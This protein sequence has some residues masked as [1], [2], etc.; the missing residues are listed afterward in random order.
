M[1]FVVVD[2]ENGKVKGFKKSTMLGREYFN[3]DGIPYMKAP[4]GKLRFRDAQLPDNWNETLDAS[5]ARPSYLMFPSMTNEVI[6]QEDA[7]TV[8][9]ATPYLNPSK[10][11]PV[12]VYI[13]GGGFQMS[14]GVDD[15]FGGDFLLQ[16]DI[17]YV[18]MN[19][20]VGPFGFLSLSDPTLNIPGNAGLKDQVL[21][22]KWVQKNIARFGG[23]PNNVTLFGTSVSC[24]LIKIS[25]DVL[26]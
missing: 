24:G 26:L 6:G 21:A 5:G 4:V 12:A 1:S 17:I 10:P 7:G 22:L 14:Y 25:I 8:S 18:T 23:D 16:K 20:R 11:L 15:M 13:H 3:F 9:V 2:T 19:Y